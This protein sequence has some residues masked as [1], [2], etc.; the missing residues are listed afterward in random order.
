MYLLARSAIDLHA[1]MQESMVT[2][3][4]SVDIGRSVIIH[5]DMTQELMTL[6][7]TQFA[8]ISIAGLRRN[9]GTTE[10]VQYRFL[11]QQRR[12]TLGT[13][14][15]IIK[16]GVVAIRTKVNTLHKTLPLGIS[17]LQQEMI[18]MYEFISHVGNYIVLFSYKQRRMS[19]CVCLFQCQ[20]KRM[21]STGYGILTQL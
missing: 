3:L 20:G 2:F 10:M 18:E 15:H 14:L 4:T 12:V 21:H 9:I 16:M 5:P 13:S 17:Q 6:G 8:V 19:L 7:T 11:L 1:C